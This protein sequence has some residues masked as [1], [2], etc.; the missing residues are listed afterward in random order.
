MRRI[1]FL[2][3]V[4]AGVSAAPAAPNAQPLPEA[5]KALIGKWIV[6]SVEI[7]GKPT[8]AQIGQKPGDIISIKRNDQQFFLS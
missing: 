5:H 2:L 1:P 3:L 7:D 4:A 6:R 8:A